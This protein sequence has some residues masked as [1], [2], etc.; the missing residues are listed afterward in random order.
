MN[1]QQPYFITNNI[2]PLHYYYYKDIEYL[3]QQLE[4][5]TKIY[6]AAIKRGE[7]FEDVKRIYLAMKKT[8]IELKNKSEQ[9]G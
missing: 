9:P 3:Q 7:I 1:L 8:K 6:Y 2:F 4:M 5:L